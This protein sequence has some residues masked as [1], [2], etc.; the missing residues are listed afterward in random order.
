M[1]TIPTKYSSMYD[2]DEVLDDLDFEYDYA[3]ALADQ[4][5]VQ[6]TQEEWESL[7]LDQEIAQNHN[8]S[9]EE[10]LMLV[11]GIHHLYY[12]TYSELAAGILTIRNIRQWCR[13]TSEEI[14]YD[15]YKEVVGEWY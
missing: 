3:E 11:W 15:E 7:L 1:I 8:K 13:I 10:E 2:C 14:E 5:Q 6:Y 9:T 4:I 12:D